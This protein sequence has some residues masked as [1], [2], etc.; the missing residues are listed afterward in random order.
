M[1][2]L[3][4]E[5]I[6]PF[7]AGRYRLNKF[8]EILSAEGAVLETRNV[9][10]KKVVV[11]EWIL[12]ALEYEVGWVICIV[13]FSVHLPAY[14]WKRIEV[15]Y[16]DANPLNTTVANVSYRFKD[17][18]L[19]VQGIPGFYYVPYYTNYAISPKGEL[20]SLLRNKFVSWII[21]NYQV[22]KNIKGGYATCR[23]VRDYGSSTYISRHRAMALTF[24]KYLSSPLKLVVNH[25]DGIPGN[26][27][28]DNLEWVTHVQNNQHAIDSGLMPNSTIKLLMKN[29][30]SGVVKQFNSV[31]ACARELGCQEQ[32]VRRRLFKDSTKR[33][34]DGLTFKLDDDSTW[35]ELEESVRSSYNRRV[36]IARDIFTGELISFDNVAQ[37]ADVVKTH[38]KL[39]ADQ[40]SYELNAPVHCYNFRYLTPDIAWPLHSEKDLKIYRFSETRRGPGVVVKNLNGEEVGFYESK[41]SA[42]NALGV[43]ESTILRACHGNKPV[44]GNL[45]SFHHLPKE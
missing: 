2:V 15:I 45:L 18:P 14:A 3:E 10:G 6:L 43:S 25:K 22:K 30:Q 9:N 35:P 33:Y 32:V 44:N 7:S 24:V 28:P 16:E 11:L 17:G 1:F 34:P 31:A 39:V 37:V 13:H 12:G 42:V 19:E 21:S 40:L 5:K 29:L 38:A 41:Q 27:T 8:G 26:D 20:L 23:G 36:I 4:E